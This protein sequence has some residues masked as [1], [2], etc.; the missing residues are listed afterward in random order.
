MAAAAR[1]PPRRLE[2]MSLRAL[3]KEAEDAGVSEADEKAALVKLILSARAAAP[4]PDCDELAAA[5][6]SAPTVRAL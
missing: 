2:N 4:P 3:Q 1:A 6:G 5:L